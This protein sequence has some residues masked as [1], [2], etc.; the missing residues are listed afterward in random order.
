M[1]NPLAQHAHDD[2]DEVLYVIAGEGVQQMSG[3]ETRLEAGVYV[4]V[5]RGTPHMLTKRGSRPLVLLSTLQGKGC[6]Q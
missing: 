2:G 3:R 1:N 5:P 4:V 6:T